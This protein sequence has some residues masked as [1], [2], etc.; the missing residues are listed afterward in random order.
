MKHKVLITFKH[1]PEVISHFQKYYEVILA[2]G[3]LSGE[4][5]VKLAI[6]H[7]V[8]ALMVATGQHITAEL[9]EKLPET[10]KIIATSS[11][12]FDHLNRDGAK[13]KNIIL[14][15]TPDVLSDC[16]ADLAMTLLLNVSRRSRE[17]LKV[18]EHGWERLFEQ[19]E[20]LGVSLKGK[21]LGILGMGSIGQEFA[22]RARAF[23]MNINYCN[24]KQLP[25]EKESGAKYFSQFEEMIPHCDVISLHAPATPE[26]K[27]IMNEKTFAL[28][29]DGSILI[30]VARG[31]LIN[32]NELIK[33]LESKKLFGVGLDVFESEPDFNKNILSYTNVFLTPHMGSA[34]KETRNAM[35]LLAFENINRVLDGESPLTEIK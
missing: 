17:Y 3:H 19:S 4:E 20:M 6:E 18:M 30:N 22:N 24:R 32:E 28:M 12:G 16:T 10:V 33:N 2:D 31:S 26:T 34:T 1:T 27:Y 15:N 5:A 23:G 25:L 11:V 14:T 9:M 13:K 35:G 8:S 21:T 29:K 7:K